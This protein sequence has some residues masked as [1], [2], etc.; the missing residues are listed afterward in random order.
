MV[1]AGA[2]L[3]S[4]ISAGVLVGM[5][6][7]VGWY[8]YFFLISLSSS[9]P[10]RDSLWMLPSWVAVAPVTPLVAQPL[11]SRLVPSEVERLETS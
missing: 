3:A 6:A 7:S 10:I 2:L 4:K 8:S 5:S 9:A 11:V 1:A